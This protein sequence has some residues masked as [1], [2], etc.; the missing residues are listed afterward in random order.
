[1][2]VT[3]KWLKVNLK[4]Y[5]YLTMSDNKLVK[6]LLDAA[7]KFEDFRKEGL[8]LVGVALAPVV[9]HLRHKPTKD[10]AR[11]V[12][13]GAVHSGKIE[14]AVEVPSQEGGVQEDLLR[15]Q[16]PQELQLIRGT[17]APTLSQVV[18]HVLGHCAVG[19]AAV[20]EERRKLLEFGPQ[21]L[22]NFDIHLPL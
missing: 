9:R 7:T 14:T 5:V 6:S 17:L 2:K 1:M 12:V 22:G 13:D 4:P 16:N 3:R 20:D 8:V 10:L 21:F 15:R 19:D 11:I 18:V